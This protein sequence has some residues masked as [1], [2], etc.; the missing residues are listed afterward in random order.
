MCIRVAMHALT[1][2]K[3]LSPLSSSS[4][5]IAVAQGNGQLR[6][7]L[8]AA[9]AV[10]AV[11]QLFGSASTMRREG[12]MARTGVCDYSPSERVI[13]REGTASVSWPQQAVQLRHLVCIA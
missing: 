12:G 10:V 2:H 6:N 11:V 3:P 9:L 5:L 8:L 7:A 4:C 1:Q 13:A